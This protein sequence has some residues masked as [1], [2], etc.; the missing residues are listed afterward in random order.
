VAVMIG[1]WRGTRRRGGL[2]WQPNFGRSDG[3]GGLGQKFLERWGKG[4]EDRG[5]AAESRE[6]ESRAHLRAAYVPGRAAEEPICQRRR[7]RIG[8]S[9]HFLGRPSGGILHR[10][11]FAGLL[12]IIFFRKQH[13]PNTT[14]TSE[15]ITSL[16]C[17]V[18]S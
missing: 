5:G 16:V 7:S 4:N 17:L 13:T 6:R 10:L 11:R 1:E 2:P 12:Y 18:V 3:G 14:F 9:F 15:L 8:A